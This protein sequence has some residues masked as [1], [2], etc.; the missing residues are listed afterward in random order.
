MCVCAY[1][2]VPDPDERV[3]ELGVDRLQVFEDE[4]LVEHA[5]I[6]GQGEACIYK[7]AVE[8]GLHTDTDTHTHDTRIC[9]G[10]YVLAC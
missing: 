4:F 8:Q 10:A 6:E 9:A 3:V 1:I 5:L 7:L 2:C